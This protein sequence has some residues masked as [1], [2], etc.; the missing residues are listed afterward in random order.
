MEHCFLIL[1]GIIEEE[2][3]IQNSEH[4]MQIQYSTGNL[5]GVPNVIDKKVE[6]VLQ[7]VAKTECSYLKI[8][9]PLMRE[10]FESNK[11]F[12]DLCYKESLAT[13]LVLYHSDKH[14]FNKYVH[15]QLFNWAIK[16]KLVKSTGQAE[17][18]LEELLLPTFGAFVFE[19]EFISLDGKQKFG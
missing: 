5:V 18:M 2:I 9:I 10:I 6:S 8:P 3:K 13:F 7:M 15:L 16:A 1:E 17:K 19:G 4:L 11:K 14:K 12:E